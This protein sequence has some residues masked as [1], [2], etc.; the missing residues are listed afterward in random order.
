MA[1]CA[2]IIC[3]LFERP[4]GSW[5]RLPPP[6]CGTRPRPPAGPRPVPRHGPPRI[7]LGIAGG[8]RCRFFWAASQALAV[9]VSWKP[10]SCLACSMRFKP[11]MLPST[12]VI[13]DSAVD[14]SDCERRKPSFPAEWLLCGVTPGAPVDSPAVGGGVPQAI[15]GAPPPLGVPCLAVGTPPPPL[16]VSTRAAPAAP[17]SARRGGC[18]LG[19]GARAGS[20]AS[21]GSCSPANGSAKSTPPSMPRMSPTSTSGSSP[22]SSSTTRAISRAHLS[23][24]LTK[25]PRKAAWSCVA[26]CLHRSCRRSHG[27]FTPS[28]RMLSRAFTPR[29]RACRET[30]ADWCSCESPRHLR[31]RRS[32][33]Q[34]FLPRTPRQRACTLRRSRCLLR[35]APG[36]SNSA[37]RQTAPPSSQCQGESD[38]CCLQHTSRKDAQKSRRRR[39]AK[40]TSSR[41]MTPLPTMVCL[42]FS[43]LE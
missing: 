14:E 38:A 17:V 19:A 32:L 20:G 12:S 13:A 4:T 8:F 6:P 16:A 10:H 37:P 29:H 34:A 5:E 21:S 3:P 42:L 43:S 40:R 31:S 27:G 9:A 2:L 30:K 28:A 24:R 23:F 11:R 26:A 7:W 18:L 33:A 41:N 22:S 1:S 36:T 25:E 35:S 39:S 15:V